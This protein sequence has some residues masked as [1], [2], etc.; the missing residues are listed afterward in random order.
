MGL[1]D[2]IKKLFGGGK[3]DDAAT[4]ADP[5]AAPEAPA[6]PTM[7]APAA[8]IGGSGSGMDATPAPE[9]SLDSTPPVT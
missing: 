7:D 5:T 3:S 9:G 6:A 1:L 2:S 4:T 8:D